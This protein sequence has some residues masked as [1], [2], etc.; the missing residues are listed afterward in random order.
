[1]NSASSV[2]EVVKGSH[3]VFLVTN[4]WETAQGE[5]EIAQGKNVADAAKKAGVSHIIFS[6]LINVTKATN[7]RLSHVPHFDG[8]SLIEEYIK[9]TGVKSTIVLPGY[10]MSNLLSMIRKGEDGV[11]RLAYPVSET[12]EF[13]LFDAAEDTGEF[14]IHSDPTSGGD[15]HNGL[16]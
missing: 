13:P 6:S 14:S 8:K 7:G 3:T 10:F 16:I 1:M 4:Y 12:S 2:E 5:V 11:F 15:S 9:S